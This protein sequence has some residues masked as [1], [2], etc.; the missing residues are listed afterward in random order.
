M[1]FKAI[2]VLLLPLAVLCAFGRASAQ[3]GMFFDE[4]GAGFK[5]AAMGQAFTAVADDHSAAYYNPAGLP[6]TEK[7]F[8]FT[9]G[10]IYAKPR[11][12]AAC[13]RAC[14]RPCDRV[15]NEFEIP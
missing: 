12:R 13:E 1:R 7:M 15:L 10:Y 6:Q 14:V 5:S 2:R 9:A 8:E 3:T 11:L 4:F